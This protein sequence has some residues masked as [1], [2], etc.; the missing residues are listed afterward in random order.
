MRLGPIQEKWL[1][2]LPRHHKTEGV[3]HEK[4]VGGLDYFCCLGVFLNVLGDGCWSDESPGVFV[5]QHTEFNGELNHEHMVILGLHNRAGL[6]SESIRVH[7]HPYTSLV[8]LNDNGPFTNHAQMADF[9][10]EHADKIFTEPK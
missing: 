10:R 8:H 7:G 2:E 9:I 6:F 5:G 1:E 4:V 3:L